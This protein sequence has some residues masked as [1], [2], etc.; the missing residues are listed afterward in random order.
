MKNLL[1]CFLALAATVLAQQS[2]MVD[3]KPGAL[4]MLSTT[5]G[6]SVDEEIQIAKAAIAKSPDHPSGYVALAMAECKQAREKYDSGY[7]N[8]ADAQIERALKLGPDNFEAQK[9]RVTVLLGRHEYAHALE[10][11][12]GLNRRTPDDLVVYGMIFDAAMQLGDYDKAENAGQWMLRL[13]PGNIPA[14]ERAAEFR[15]ITGDNDGAVRL[16]KLALDSTADTD[17]FDRARMLAQMAQAYQSSGRLAEAIEVSRQALSVDAASYDALL[18]ASQLELLQSD[19]AKAAQ[20][21]RDAYKVAPGVRHLYQFASALDRAGSHDEAKSLF[22][23]FEKKAVAQGSSPD[24]ANRELI[25]YYADHANR[26]ADAL[27]I[28]TQEVVARHDVRTLDAY[29]WALYKNGKYAEARKQ[30]ERVFAVG[31]IDPSMLRHAGEIETKLG[32]T[33][34]AKSYFEQASQ[35]VH[36]TT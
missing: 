11:A 27:R 21:A 30:I 8:H 22:A 29:A 26:P 20:F 6:F 5:A 2:A 33:A 9:A 28:A 34:K 25:F 16:W 1:I 31:I 13:R 3:S 18:M 24:N 35:L 14:F 15:Q 19:S 12:E 36:A 23:E 17:Y 4:P 10:L 32:E 7:Y